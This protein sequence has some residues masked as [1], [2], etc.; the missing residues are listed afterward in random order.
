MKRMIDAKGLT[1]PL[2]VIE[3]RK[4]LKEMADGVL[5]VIVDNNIALQNLAKMA[6]QLGLTHTASTVNELEYHLEIVVGEGSQVEE[7]PRSL[8][9]NLG[10]QVV[11]LASAQMG[12]GDPALGKILMRSFLY[13]LT[14]LEQLP[15]KMV[16]Y[17]S[18]VELACKG[19]D[20]LVD[21][22]LLAE[23]GV[24]VL[25]C[26]TCLDFYQLVPELAVGTIT[27]MYEIARIQMEAGQI[28]QP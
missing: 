18:G 10:E 8:K 9:P 19:S 15:A 23:R 24:E 21:L 20:S 13:T 5:V 3:T 11:V 4:A 27:N 1:C 7:T 16:L 2:P 22:Q 17:N 12:T 26:G 14:E 6:R 28:I 25:S